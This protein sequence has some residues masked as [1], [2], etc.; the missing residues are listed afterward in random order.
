VNDRLREALRRKIA[1]HNKFVRLYALWSGF[2]VVCMWAGIYFV[3]RWAVIF[4]RTISQGVDAEMPSSYPSGFLA[5]FLVWFVAGCL[6]RIFRPTPVRSNDRNLLDIFL[7]FVL[8]P[9]RATL[10]IL[11]HLQQRVSLQEPELELAATLLERIGRAGKL[12]ADGVPGLFPPDVNHEHLTGALQTLDLVYVRQVKGEE[13]L[14]VTEPQ[15]L[16]PFLQ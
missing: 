3:G 2:L 6:E 1:R 15:K 11:R 14:A 9:A 5:V 12:R 4:I 13:Y 10:S 7:E 8:F 16:T